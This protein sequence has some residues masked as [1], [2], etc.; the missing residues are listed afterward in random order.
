MPLLWLLKFSSIAKSFFS[1][2]FEEP[3]R[4][5]V[6]VLSLI[7][8]VVCAYAGHEKKAA[9]IATQNVEVLKSAIN[10]TRVEA[11]T[12]RS[13]EIARQKVVRDAEEIDLRSKLDVA[14]NQLRSR[15][16]SGRTVSSNLPTPATTTTYF[17]GTSETPLLDAEV[18]TA[19]VIKAEGWQDW[20]RKAQGASMIAK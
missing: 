13:A 10:R 18:C 19:A 5:I 6:F 2:L 16:Y 4:F 7:F 15:A 9:R 1:W 20:Y 11:E 8:I 14:L 12:A 17:A 3:A